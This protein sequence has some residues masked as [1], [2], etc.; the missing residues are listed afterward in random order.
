MEKLN[1]LNYLPELRNAAS[2]AGRSCPCWEKHPPRPVEAR[3]LPRDVSPLEG[4][5]PASEVAAWVVAV[6]SLRNGQE[7]LSE[8][9]PPLKGE[10]LSGSASAS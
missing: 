6:G 7:V 1:C 8:R 9:I 5:I 2:L 10:M 3:G 4:G